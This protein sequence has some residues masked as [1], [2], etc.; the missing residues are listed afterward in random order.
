MRFFAYIEHVIEAL[1]PLVG[2]GDE[3]VPLLGQLGDISADRPHE[4]SLVFIRTSSRTEAIGAVGTA[5]NSSVTGAPL[6]LC[7]RMR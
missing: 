1:V 6:V 4:F 7:E 5:A 3:D 2:V